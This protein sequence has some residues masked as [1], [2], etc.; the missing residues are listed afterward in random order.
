MTSIEVI[1]GVT[2]DTLSKELLNSDTP[3]LLK[4]FGKDWP[5]PQLADEHDKSAM[6]YLMEFYRGMHVSAGLG[7]PKCKGRIFYNEEVTGFNFKAGNV[8]LNKVFER[9]L[10][11]SK[12]QNPPA[13]YIGSTNVEKLLPGF[14]EQHFV[15]LTAENAVTNI[16][17][18]NQSRIAAHYDFP[19]NLACCLFGQ[20]RFTLFPPEQLENLYVGPLELS[21]G[22]QEISMV[23]FADPD[24]EKYPKFKTALKASI[25]ADLDPGDALF[26][27]GMWWHHVEA[28]QSLNVLM[29]HWWRPEPLIGGRPM[30]ALQLAIM[31]VRDLPKEQR[32][33]WK[34]QFN[35]YVFEHDK[36]NHVHIPEDA[37]GMLH[38]PITESA[39][40]NIKRNVINKLKS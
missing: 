21:P 11:H 27:P 40:M 9:I 31:S 24:F 8:Q 33:A 7:D 18:G 15:D 14:R 37:Q 22:G 17:I 26:L 5:L 23:D 25:V 20:R 1:E 3:I 10:Q 16:W 39:V 6:D 30:D 36:H 19:A 38:T 12:D 32:E 13:V 34:N 28:F 4:G 2:P 29:T 35:Y